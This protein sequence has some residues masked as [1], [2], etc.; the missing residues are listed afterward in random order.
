[1]GQ[2]FEKDDPTAKIKRI[3]FLEKLAQWH[4]FSLQQ[5]SSLGELQHDAS[6]RKDTAAVFAATRDHLKKLLKFRVMAFFMVEEGGN[7]F[8]LKD[9]EPQEARESIQ[10]EI[11]LL[12][13]N[14]TFAWALNQNRPV[15]VKA[16]N[17]DNGL[18]LHVLTTKSRVRGM[19]IGVVSSQSPHVDETIT[20]PMSII[21]QHT[22]N[23]LESAALYHL[24]YEQNKNLEE[25]VQKRTRSLEEQTAKLR[26]EIAYRKLAEEALLVAKQEAEASARIKSEFLDNMSHEIRTPLNAIL[27][28]S[29]ILHYE[30]SRLNRTE[31]LDDLKAIETAGKHLLILIN[32]ILDLSKI[33]A[34]K[35]E[36]YPET[37]HIENLINELSAT[38]LPLATKNNNVF[39]VDCS[40]EIGSMR[41]DSTRIRQIVL[42]LLSNACKFTENGEIQFHISREWRDGSE[43]VHFKVTDT[44]I[45]IKSENLE[46]IFGEFTQADASTTRKYGGTGLGLPISRRLSQMLNGWL[47]VESQFK[48]GSTFTLT[49]P[50][51]HMQTGQPEAELAPPASPPQGKA[52]PMDTAAVE[53]IPDVPP[54]AKTVLVIDDDPMVRDLIKRFL[55]KEGFWVVG[56]SSGDE[57]IALAKKL[58]PK[59]ITLD[60]MM[61]DK[62]GWDVLQELKSQPALSAIPVI[63]L[64][65]VNEREKGFALGA[66]EYITKPLDWEKLIGSIKKLDKTLATDPI[67]YIDGDVTGREMLTRILNREGWS[68]NKTESVNKALEHLKTQKPGMILMNLI[69]EDMNAFDFLGQLKRNQNWKD[70]P[71][72]IL[73][74]R[75]LAPEERQKLYPAVKSIFHKGKFTRQELTEALHRM[76]SKTT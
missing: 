42:N 12:I 17:F 55:S 27:G 36:L 65:V 14:G 72:A 29:E 34:G 22:A 13:E 68:V 7:D 33:Q 2:T 15:A 53:T 56:A 60:V 67:L 49:V 62:N 26:E 6:L 52:A 40:Q 9:F 39:K 11:D 64:S 3:E 4:L 24:F 37:F 74:A 25:T 76:Q 19:F 45:G 1:M 70:I 71:V 10:K 16:K 73:T 31:F 5:L 63:L 23:T 59:I 18:V 28:Y 48:K 35:M 47:M 44:G 46:K 43:W 38:I 61:P 30:L 51:D 20:Y 57:G 54:A 66:A 8:I 41:S 69:L 32:D 58:R 50:A 21:L 75:E